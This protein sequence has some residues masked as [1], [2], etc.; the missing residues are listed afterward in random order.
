MSRL[1]VRPSD[2]DQALVR[3]ILVSLVVGWSYINAPATSL[4]EALH[5]KYFT[6]AFVYWLFSLAAYGWTFYLLRYLADATTILIA[7]RIISIFADIGALS[8]YTAIAGKYGVV[9]LPIYMNSIIGYG[10]RFGVTYL[11][12][13]LAVAA[14]F[15]AVS[16]QFN[17]FINSSRELIAAYFLGMTLVPV[18]AASLLRKHSE[19]LDRVRDLN[20]ARARFIA[21]MSHELRTP[22]HA[23]ISVSDV[24]R[25]SLSQSDSR[26]AIAKKMQII[27]DSAQH[28][29]GLV[30]KILDVAATQAGKAP[31]RESDSLD[32]PQVTQSALRICKPNALE[33]GI[34]FYWYF[35]ASLPVTL[36]G[37]ADYLQEILINTVGNA[38]KHTPKGSVL[39]KFES[40]VREACPCMRIAIADTGIGIPEKLLPN[41]FEPFT[42]GDD[43]TG[44]LYAGTGL[45]L[46]LT[47]QYVEILG[48]SIQVEST[49]G[50]G[51][52]F[53][54]W[55][56]LRSSSSQGVEHSKPSPRNCFLITTRLPLDDERLA[57]ESAGWV[58]EVILPAE[59]HRIDTSDTVIFVSESAFDQAEG[60]ISE[61]LARGLPPLVVDYRRGSPEAA[62]SPQVNSRAEPGNVRELR[63]VRHLA[64]AFFF[65]RDY[66]TDP[67]V[68]TVAA[69]VLVADDNA[70][71]LATARMALE[72]VGHRVTC[73]SS[74]DAALSQLD[75]NDFAVAFIDMHM[76]GMSGIEVAQ[77]YQ[78]MTQS[79]GTPIVILT[80]DATPE[81]KRSAET[82]GAVAY[83]TKPLGAKELRYAVE[84]YARG[85]SLKVSSPAERNL[86]ALQTLDVSELDELIDIG[87]NREELL[88]MVSVFEVDSVELIDMAITS[89]KDND[90]QRTQ[91]AMHALKGAAATLGAIRLSKLA[92]RFERETASLFGRPDATAESL[93]RESL[94]ESVR[95]ARQRIS[96]RCSL[97]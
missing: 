89:S 65:Q 60:M 80:A 56:P 95:C 61:L 59:A 22:L 87:V 14:A 32:L 45:G 66:P 79:K 88:E 41:I 35:D 96:E 58:C 94:E 97:Q 17:E 70:I 4:A 48:G 72:S 81:A 71:N 90:I 42:L 76:P 15:F 26:E 77:I 83:M 64:D 91:E 44:R 13:T 36:Y 57:F 21:N 38:I 1:D 92:A 24:L 5:Y 52:Q 10:Y 86:N 93:L 6:L 68:T 9:L 63:M 84:C 31:T 8:A 82:S 33:R 20:D 25:E 23:I 30:N 29:L 74:G 39:V 85:V 75:E 78:F 51:T 37:N 11:Y 50:V 67:Q 69:S 49:E 62:S 7:S 34:S 28:L 47:K 73:V 40:V 55:L 2:L 18:Y 16:L 3:V 19:V 53:T 12:F 43:S 46:T 54:I 27:T